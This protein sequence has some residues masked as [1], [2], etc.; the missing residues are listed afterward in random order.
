MTAIIVAT[1]FGHADMVQ[2]ILGLHADPNLQDD[3][4]SKFLFFELQDNFFCVFF[5]RL[6]QKILTCTQIHT[7]ASIVECFKGVGCV[8]IVL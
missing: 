6:I 2:Y 3:V 5:E 7:R 1:M 8:S 4:S